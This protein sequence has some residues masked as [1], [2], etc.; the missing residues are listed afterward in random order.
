MED[1]QRVEVTDE[2]R[3][4]LVMQRLASGPLVV[5]RL[6]PPSLPPFLPP[7]PSPNHLPLQVLALLALLMYFASWTRARLPDVHVSLMQSASAV[8]TVLP[9]FSTRRTLRSLTNAVSLD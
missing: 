7:L 8:V 5:H 3:G 1:Q 6:L 2:C 9:G 4:K